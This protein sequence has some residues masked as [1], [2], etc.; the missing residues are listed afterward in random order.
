MNRKILLIGIIALLF[1]G[2]IMGQPSRAAAQ[3]VDY[4]CVV[5][6]KAGVHYGPNSG[7]ALDGLLALKY[8]ED[9]GVSGIYE[10][11]D[12]TTQ[13]SLIGEVDGHS[14]SLAFDLGDDQYVFGVGTAWDDMRGENC[15]Q[16]VGGPLV[17]PQESDMGDWQLV[18]LPFGVGTKFQVSVLIICQEIEL[19]EDEE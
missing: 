8:D 16:V 1:G 4:D 7:L 10:S 11:L 13:Y 12:G 15:G 9:G 19:E 18:C 6:F 3:E 14:V 2:V 17:G 5:G